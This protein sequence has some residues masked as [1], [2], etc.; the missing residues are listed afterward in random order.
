MEDI[1]II[2]KTFNLLIV[3]HGEAFHNLS[4]YTLAD[5]D[6]TYEGNMKLMN[7]TLT[8][9]GKQQV[10]L[11]S[12]RLKDAKFDV[13]ISSDLKRT[14][15]TAEAIMKNNASIETLKRW[16]VARE[17]CMGDFEG[18]S[19]VSRALWIIENSGI[20]ESD[21][22]NW[23]PPN[24]ESKA[25]FRS[26]VK[27]FLQDVQDEALRSHVTCPLILVVCHGAFMGELYSIISTSEYGKGLPTK[28]PRY[29]NTGIVQYSLTFKH[30]GKNVTTLEKVECPL[31]SCSKHLDNHDGS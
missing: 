19:D 8:E 27:K 14:L 28:G 31:F 4:D 17:R 3:R 26:R 13:A 25:E 5:S 30:D 23:R 12:D 16:S 15:Q 29:D 22:L 18:I 11:V 1:R 24:G 20:I 7:T 10:K 2:E 21:K 6:F 9:K